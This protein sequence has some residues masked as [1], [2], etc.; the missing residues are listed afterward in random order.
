MSNRARM[1]ISQKIIYGIENNISYIE[2]KNILHQLFKTE[3]IPHKQLNE[4][5]ILFVIDLENLSIKNLN[6]LKDLVNKRHQQ[7]N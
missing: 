3:D 5:N 1:R 2:K 6:W 4:K 7:S